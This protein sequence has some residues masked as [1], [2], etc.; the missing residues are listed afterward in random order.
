MNDLATQMKFEEAEVLRR[1]LEK[2]QRARSEVKE[3]FFSV[4]KFDFLAL[5]PSNTVSRRKLA[6]IREGKV[7]GFEEYDVETLRERL[8]EDLHRFF[9]SPIDKDYSGNP[10]DEFCLACNFILDP[11]LSVEMLPVQDV[12]N[13]PMH[14][15][16]RIQKRKRRVNSG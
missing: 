1:R 6:F 10:Y 5:L 9:D 8:E 15:L 12:E 11:L 2:V 4:S 14:V 7:L 3:T 16:E 13:L